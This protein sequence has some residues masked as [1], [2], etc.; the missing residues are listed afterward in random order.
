[1]NGYEKERLIVEVA[2][3]IDSENGTPGMSALA[4]ARTT[5]SL[6]QNRDPKEAGLLIRALNDIAA[7]P[8]MQRK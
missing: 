3:A 4:L 6:V 5:V 2:R 8:E 1:M 7:M